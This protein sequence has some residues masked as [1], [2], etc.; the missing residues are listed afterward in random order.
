VASGVITD[1]AGGTCSITASQAASG[2]Y[3]AATPVSQSYTV[4]VPLDLRRGQRLQSNRSP[5][6]AA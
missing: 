6:T 3:A 4:L 5:A 2:N 1:L